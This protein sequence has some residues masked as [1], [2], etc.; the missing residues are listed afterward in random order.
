[1]IN[2]EI[3]E[4]WLARADDDFQFALINFKEGKTFFSQICFHL[5]R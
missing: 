2:R 3:V 4:E 5:Q 1:M